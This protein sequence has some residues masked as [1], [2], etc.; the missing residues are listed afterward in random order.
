MSLAVANQPLSTSTNN[1]SSTA[2]AATTTV[3]GKKKRSK[4][5]PDI[6]KDSRVI[7]PTCTIHVHNDL[8][9]KYNTATWMNDIFKH[10]PATRLNAV[11]IPG[12][13]DSATDQMTKHSPYA[14]FNKLHR[15][16]PHLVYLW[17]KTQ[18]H[19]IYS[20]LMDGIR[21]LDLRIENHHTGWKT[22]HGLLSNCFVNALDD[23]ARFANDHKREIIIVDFQHL[24]NFEF[25][26]HVELTEYCIKHPVLGPRLAGNH[27][28]AD[29]TF[30][31]FWKADKNV[32]MF[33]N[34]GFRHFSHLYWKRCSIENPW[35]NTPKKHTLQQ[36][37]LD[38]ITQRHEHKFHVSQ[39]ILT[40]DVYRVVGGFFSDVS[41]LFNLTIPAVSG[42]IR[43]SHV[44]EALEQRARSAGT[45]LNIVI[46]DFY[47]HSCFVERCLNINMAS[48]K[49]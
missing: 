17:A 1:T 7:N 39:L 28:G 4:S 33:Y 46:V 35:H 15:I 25:D 41:S 27:L 20:Q 6:K 11:V 3:V 31:D 5:A 49:A 23:I 32:V 47:E 21:Y 44:L 14:K 19:S 12:S 40:P 30:L 10:A 48:I 38:G 22:F 13:H 43:D 16:S 24:V 42:L 26:D 8:F 9:Y 18:H 29:G 34:E 2:A 36:K 37:L 45:H